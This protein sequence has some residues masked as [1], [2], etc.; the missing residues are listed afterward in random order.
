MQDEV[1]AA[2]THIFFGKLRQ[3]N[4]AIA[5]ERQQIFR[6]ALHAV[7]TKFLKLR[8]IVIADF[9]AEICRRVQWK[10]CGFDFKER[11]GK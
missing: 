7:A 6:N 8:R 1:E 10:S 5:L 3:C 9:N 4:I 2:I 11:E